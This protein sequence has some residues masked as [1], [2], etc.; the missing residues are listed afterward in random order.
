ML[1]RS[2]GILTTTNPSDARLKKDVVGIGFGLQEILS[3]RPVSFVW[4][5]PTSDSSKLS[6]GFIAQEVQTVIPELV[7]EYAHKDDP[8]AEDTVTR[9]G[10][11][12]E[13][14]YVGLVAAIQELN[15]KV[16][17]LQAEVDALKGA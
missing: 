10:L 5:T 7:S 1:F 14:I 16:E 2:N 17:T 6:Y 12:K 9:L 13:G 3:L 8:Y 15:A 4:D 11:D